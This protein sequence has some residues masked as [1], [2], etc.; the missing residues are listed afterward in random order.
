MLLRINGQEITESDYKEK[1]NG[2]N[3][4]HLTWN[5]F[6]TV[7]RALLMIEPPGMIIG[8]TFGL[9]IGDSNKSILEISTLIQCLK[10]LRS[11][12]EEG[13]V[14]ATEEDDENNE[15]T[16]DQ[17]SLRF[18]EFRRLLLDYTFRDVIG[19]QKSSL[20]ILYKNLKDVRSNYWY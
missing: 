2:T 5:N 8:D 17:T 14:T 9:L 11:D 4:Q 6:L 3:L 12:I 13:S 18:R 20:D 16:F 19:A 1:I 10:V 15:E 7:S